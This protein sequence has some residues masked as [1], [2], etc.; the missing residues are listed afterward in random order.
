MIRPNRKSLSPIN[1]TKYR[2]SFKVQLY[3]GVWC[4][5]KVITTG[6]P[7]MDTKYIKLYNLG[8]LL[9]LYNIL[10]LC[11]TERQRLWILYYF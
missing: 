9:D 3:L 10:F 8:K 7:N 11:L 1:L 4:T 5:L 6:I 2:D